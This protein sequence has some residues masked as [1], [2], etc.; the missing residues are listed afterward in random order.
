[1]LKFVGLTKIFPNLFEGEI[2][3]H[4]LCTVQLKLQLLWIQQK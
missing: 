2:K 1:M 3:N 4:Y